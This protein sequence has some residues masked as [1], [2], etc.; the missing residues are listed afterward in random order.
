MLTYFRSASQRLRSW[1][2]SPQ[3]RPIRTNKLY[4]RLR[5]EQLEERALPATNLNSVI[6]SLLVEHFPTTDQNPPGT[7]TF[8]NS[9]DPTL[10]PTVIAV[11]TSVA[12]GTAD[13]EVK[14]V[15]LTF[16]GLAFVSGNWTGNVV[17][18][19]QSGVLF[20]GLLDIAVADGNDAD[21]F[22]VVGDINLA[23]GNANSYLK[24]DPIDGSTIGVPNFLDVNFQDLRLNFTDFRGDENLNSLHFEFALKGFDT[25]DSYLNSQLQGGNNPFIQ[26]NVEGFA[27]GT[28]DLPAVE[29]VATDPATF[30]DA[31]AA[32]TL[33]QLDG[34]GGKVNGKIFKIGSMKADFF[35]HRITVDGRSAGYIAVE[36][37]MHFGGGEAEEGEEPAAS[38]DFEVAVA[39]SDLGPL[40]FYVAGGPIE[41]PWGIEFEEVRFANVFNQ[42]IEGLRT[43]IDASAIAAVAAPAGSGSRVT[44]TMSPNQQHDLV[45]GDHFRIAA[46]TNTAYNGDFTVVDVVGNQVTY[47]DDLHTPAAL[48]TFTGSANI[49]RLT[50]RTPLDLRDSGLTQLFT[51]PRSMFDWRNQL[52]LQVTNQIRAGQNV[53]NQLFGKTIFGGGA[54]ITIE[55][56]S[57]KVMKV[58]ADV[59]LD[60]NGSILITGNLALGGGAAKIPASIYADL[61]RLQSGAAKFLFLADVPKIAGVSVDPLLVYR[62]SVGFQPLLNGAPV[63]LD[64]S[65]LPAGV[66]IDVAS[67]T[68]TGTGPWTVTFTLTMPAGT[69]VSDKFKVGDTLVVVNS[70]PDKFNGKHII[71]AID[72]AAGT[73]SFRI[74]L[75]VK[76]SGIDVNLDGV[77][78]ANDD[79]LFS[80][81]PVIDGKLDMDRNGVVDNDDD[82]GVSLFKLN[83]ATADLTDYQRVDYQVIDGLVDID[84]DGDVNADSDDVGAIG[85]EPGTWVA[86]SAV[87]N[88]NAF[89]DGFRITIGGGIDLNIPKVTT[90]SLETVTDTVLDFTLPGPGSAIDARIDLSFDAQLHEKSV[91]QIARFAGSFHVTIDADIPVTS[92]N[93]AGG[94][95]IWGAG[96]LT[97]DLKFLEKYGLFASASGLLRINSSNVAKT[98]VLPVANQPQPITVALPA[99]SFAMR[100]DGSADFR[101]DFDKNNSFTADESMALLQGIFV[102]D[103]SA[104]QG[105]NVALFRENSPGVITPATIQVG[106]TN[107]FGKR[108]LT[109]D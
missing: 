89:G 75:A 24:L 86:G 4:K 60:T 58:N 63:G 81:I 2:A 100:L 74:G 76:N 106:P 25:G 73:V 107:V 65:G 57:G 3:R 59:A 51:P 109:A 41:T 88:Q 7:F 1:F 48:G 53:W 56:I 20:P 16:S 103:F 43:A 5:V 38:H 66:G 32:E 98:E 45:I 62:G 68:V 79:G 26:I 44:L 21:A 46:S 96:L 9:T 34:F 94:V 13:L 22:G 92:T 84:H 55:G 19:A 104:E 61:T 80:Q 27:S 36:G 91:G 30:Q 95:E 28:L 47:E 105:F 12:G 49:I 50:I 33:H 54:T 42:T 64:P 52:D 18:N 102:L 78:D 23:Q 35:F 101:I 87:A 71:T 15:S 8:S 70:N 90:I 37:L 40:Q 6:D 17:V 93:P 14:D 69:N 11:G 85:T 10:V 67:A 108:L 99:K 39:I 72:D 83:L 29:S 77:I 31:L 82:G 97:S